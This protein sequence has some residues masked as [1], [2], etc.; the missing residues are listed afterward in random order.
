MNK[1]TLSA[2]ALFIFLTSQSA[3]AANAGDLDPTFGTGGKVY[4]LPTNFM[5]AE[6]VAVQADGKLILVGST[7]GPDNTQDFGIVRLNA[8]GSPDAGFGNN[9]LV[10]IQFDP[11]FNEMATSVVIQ[12]DGKI[13]VSGSVQLGSAGWDFGVV[14]LNTN[15]TLDT[16]YN[17]PVGKVKVNFGG[18]DFANDMLIQPDDKVVIVGSARPT[19]NKDLAIIRLTTTGTRDGT[20]VGAAGGVFIDIGPG[21]EDEAFGVARQS[22]G[23]LIIAGRTAGQTG[24]GDFCLV[25]MTSAGAIDTTFGF[26][27]A[28]IT[29]VGSQNDSAYSVAVQSDGK[30]VAGGIANSGSFDEAA[31]VRYTTGGQP[32]PTFDG[33]GKVTYDVRASASDVIRSVLIQADGKIIGVG[34][35]GGSYILVRLTTTGALDPSFGTGGKAIQNIAPDSSGAHRAILQPD[36]KIVAVG[37]GA[38]NG[39]FGFTAARFLTTPFSKAPFDFDGDGKTDIGIFRPLGSASEWWIN[40][41][42]TGLTFALQFGAS[43]DKLAPADYTGDGKTDIAFFRPSTGQWFVLRSEDFSFFALPFGT[44]GDIPVPAD[45]DADGK[46]DFAVFRPGTSTWFISQSSGAPTR[47]EQFGTSGDQPVVADYDGDGK[48]DVAIFRPAAGGAEWWISRSTGGVLA[49]QFGASTDK[50]VQGDYTGDGKTD[51]AIWRPS[52]GQ[53]LIL[54]SEDF[55]FFGF[56]FGAAGDIV[57]P[58]DYDGDGK[59]DA[60]V[61]RPSNSTWFIG[62]TTAGTQIVQFGATGDRPIPNSFV[63]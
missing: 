47:I 1:L 17:N 44:N 23:S 38:G 59:F 37:D 3:F 4:N 10:G 11:N 55:S 49:L 24:G 8:N 42:S 2:F 27:G 61:F 29:P 46:A 15:G 57:A 5:P 21:N 43:T 35:S 39:T 50:A 25:R 52:T 13:V 54:R 22:D 6:D 53:W 28:A 14:R 45:Y 60:T 58:G 20:F 34:A 12:S 63:P 32:D 30:I 7:L 36:G 33:D 16:T 26:G 41:S 56:P 31:F 62:R 9:G 40:R 48:A 19:P 51:I 18:D